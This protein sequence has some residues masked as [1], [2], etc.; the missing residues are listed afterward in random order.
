MKIGEA[1]QK[2]MLQLDGLSNKKIVLTQKQE[3]LK[4]IAGK[5]EEYDALVSELKEV[6]QQYDSVRDLMAQLME[7]RT[8]LYNMEAGKRQ[9]KAMADQSEEMLK[10]LEV[11]RR[12]ASGAK[13][14]ASDEKRLMEYSSEMYMMAKNA[15]M[16]AERSDKEYDSLWDEEDGTEGQ[17]MDIGQQVDEMEI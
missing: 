10:C 9:S 15:A 16:L 5:Q 2:Y 7:R 13:V 6:N 14:P 17:E 11:Y 8:D 4:D 3:E 1:R 12:I